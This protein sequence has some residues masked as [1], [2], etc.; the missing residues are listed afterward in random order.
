MRPLRGHPHGDPRLLHRDWQELPG[1]VPD[2]I[3]ETLIEQPSPLNW[4]DH[5]P[6]RLKFAVSR[7]TEANPEGKAA[8]TQQIQGDCLPGYLMHAPPR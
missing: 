8:R 2:Q 7:T 3:I 6:E 4:I 1:P 5:L